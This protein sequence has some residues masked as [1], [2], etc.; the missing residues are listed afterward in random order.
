MEL[1]LRF[2]FNII[3]IIYVSS[4]RYIERWTYL[5]RILT[6]SSLNCEQ[7]VNYCQLIITIIFRCWLLLSFRYLCKIYLMPIY[8]INIVK[9]G[10]LV[11]HC[12]SWSPPISLSNIYF[13][14]I[15]YV[16]IFFDYVEIFFMGF[17][18]GID[19]ANPVMYYLAY[20]YATLLLCMFFLFFLFKI[21]S[22]IIEQYINEDT[23]DEKQ[24]I[25]TT[26]RQL[27]FKNKPLEENKCPICLSSYDEDPNYYL[28]QC[29]H[30]GHVDCLES[31]WKNSKVKQCFYF[32][33]AK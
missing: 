8:L 2:L 15:D 7:V 1:W 23:I 17:G 30:S 27:S 3:L 4:Y 10:F 21:F 32:C 26:H 31:W 6:R 33:G 14:I 29:N 19:I 24:I 18:M 12:L 20:Y 25:R 28:M 22:G 16:E 11:K 9:C 5:K 13:M